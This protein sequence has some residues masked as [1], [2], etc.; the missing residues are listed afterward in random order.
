MNTNTGI[1]PDNG[2]ITVRPIEKIIRTHPFLAG[3]SDHQYRI[4]GD[5]AMLSH[6]DAGELV[7]REGD[8]AN[9]FYLLQ[10]GK[11]ALETHT[12]KHGVVRVDTL[13]PGD[14]L[15]WSWLFPPY[16]WHFA[17]RAI[18]PTDSIFIYATPLR[19]ECESDHDFGYEIMKRMAAMMLHRLQAAR[20]QWLALSI[21]PA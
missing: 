19:D 10:D 8:P 4:L 12:A 13:G 20:H 3:L 14:A 18:E 15:G 16:F 5:C 21:P 2:G 17:A 1:E 7:F 9:R 11:V 6:F